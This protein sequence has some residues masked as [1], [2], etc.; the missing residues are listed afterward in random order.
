MYS[1]NGDLEIFSKHLIKIRKEKGYKNSRQAALKLDIP[2][3]TY[4]KY[5]NKEASPTL[6][7]IVKISQGFNISFTKLFEPFL[8]SL[9]KNKE[10]D[11]LSYKLQII[12]DDQRSQQVLAKL[13]EIIEIWTNDITGGST[14]PQGSE[15]KAIETD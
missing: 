14:A 7:N 12:M 11:D 2:Y 13:I 3:N 10:L 8:E 6:S 9:P 5:E 4:R 1:S 15:E